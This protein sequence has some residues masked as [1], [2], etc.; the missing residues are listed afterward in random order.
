MNKNAVI[1]NK[2][3]RFPNQAC[4]KTITMF[5][6]KEMFIN[7]TVNQKML[8]ETL[9]RKELN[10]LKQVYKEMLYKISNKK[11]HAKIIFGEINQS[12]LKI[13]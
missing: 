8:Q 1:K 9:L 4:S 6:S 2:N 5:N 3:K 12:I 11:L 7:Y 13:E 10:L